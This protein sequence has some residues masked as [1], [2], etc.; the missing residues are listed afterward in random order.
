MTSDFTDDQIRIVDFPETPVAMMR[1]SGD[2]ELLG[3]TIRRFVEWR[4]RTGH[5]HSTCATF[6]ILYDDPESVPPEDYRID[7]CVTTKAEIAPN[8]EG[9]VSGAIP[10]GR[11]AVLRSIGHADE[12]GKAL[13]FLYADW[14]PRSGEELRDTPLFAQRVRFPPEVTEG[15]AVTDVFLPLV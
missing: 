6:N 15:E 2:H 3:D 13:A 1:H 4:R 11:C 7:L 8:E 12:L 5:S 14:L 9:V 10:N